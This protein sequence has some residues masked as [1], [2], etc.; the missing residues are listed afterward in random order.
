M[1]NK[2]LDEWIDECR[3]ERINQTLKSLTLISI[4][5]VTWVLTNL[6]KCPS[7]L[8]P[9]SLPFSISASCFQ[10]M[11]AVLLLGRAHF[12][13]RLRWNPALSS[14]DS[15]TLVSCLGIMRNDHTADLPSRCGWHSLRPSVRQQLHSIWLIFWEGTSNP[16][17]SGADHTGEAYRPDSSICPACARPAAPS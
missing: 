5:I 17:D 11:N 4:H 9:L 12:L 13:S 3:K 14:A 10:V 15:L 8:L 16:E 7:S 2:Y 6:Y 1:F